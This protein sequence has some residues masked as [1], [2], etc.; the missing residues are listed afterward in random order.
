MAKKTKYVSKGQRRSVSKITRK[1]I[2]RERPISA[3]NLLRSYA[4]KEAIMGSYSGKDKRLATKYIAELEI[5]TEASRLI[6]RFG[7]CGLIWGAAIHAVKT[8]YT[9]KLTKKWNKIL[10]K[11]AEEESKKTGIYVN[12]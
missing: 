1:A 7:K 8:N 3:E 4:V 12:G 10:R 6:N 9:E 11:W 5:K 2:R